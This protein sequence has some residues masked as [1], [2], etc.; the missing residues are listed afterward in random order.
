MWLKILVLKKKLTRRNYGGVIF[1][2]LDK[3]L[4]RE[5]DLV[6]DNIHSLFSSASDST[7]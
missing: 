7:G 6:E 2:P 4:V 3:I 1:F 5:F